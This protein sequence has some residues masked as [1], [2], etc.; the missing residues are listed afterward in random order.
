MPGGLSHELSS[1]IATAPY[2]FDINK[3]LKVYSYT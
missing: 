3:M 2:F 1:N